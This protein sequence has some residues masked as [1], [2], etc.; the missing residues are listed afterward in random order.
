MGIAIPQVITPDRA[1]G[2]QVI[3]GSLKFDD[4]YLTRTPGSEGNLKSWTWSAWVKLDRV[5]GN[6]QML[7]E[8]KSNGTNYDGIY[9]T[10]GYALEY[11]LYRSSQQ[12]VKITNRVFRDTGWYHLVVVYDAENSTA[13]DRVRIYVNGERETSFSSS[14]NPDT[15]DNSFVN[16]NSIVHQIGD[17]QAANQEYDGRLSQVYLIDGQALDASYFG[18]TDPLTNTWKPKKFEHLSTAI[19]TQYSGASTLTWDDN[20]IGSIYTLSNGNKTATAGGGGSGYSNA[21]VWSIAIPA[22]STYAWTLDITNGDSTGGWYFTD[23]QTDSNTHADE[24]GGNSLGMRPGETH[25]GYHGT[26]ATANGGSDGQNKISMPGASPG[27]GFARVDFVV[28]RPASGTGKVWVKN[29]SSSSWVGGGDPSDT[30]STASFIIPDGTTYFGLTF[31]DRSSDQIATF[32]GDG[33]IQ[34]KIGGNSFYLPFDGNSPIG[35]DQSG[36]GNDWTPVNFGGSV[37]LDSPL[38]SG[39]RSILNTT[40]GGTQAGVGVFGSKQNVGYAVTV[41]NSGGGNKF[42]LDGVEAPTLSNLIRGVTYTFDQSDSS[43][44]THPLVFGSTAEG[45]NFARGALYGSISAGSAGAATTI[46]IPYDAP[47]TLYYHCSAHSGMGG[48]IV[49]IHTDETKADQYAS[50]CVTALPLVGSNNDVSASIA[51]TSTTKTITASNTSHPSTQSNFYSGSIYFDDTADEYISFPGVTFSGEFCVEFWYYPD[52]LATANGTVSVPLSGDT[53]D[54]FQVG[55]TSGNGI[56]FWYDGSLRVQSG[57]IALDKWYHIALTRDSSNVLRLYVDGVQKGNTPT[58]ST[59]ETV[60]TFYLGVQYRSGNADYHRTNGY[61][62]DFRIYNGTVKYSSDFV[63]PSRSPDILPDTPSG[64]VGGS[65]LTKITDGAVAFDG[66][67]DDLHIADSDDL[68]FG[69]GDFT[70]ECFAYHTEDSDDHLISKYGSSSANRSWRLVSDGNQKIIFYWYYSTDSSLNITSAAGKFSLNRWHHIVAQR[71]SGDIYLFVDGE[72]VGSNTSSGA[73]A[74]FNNNSTAVAIAGDLNGSSQDFPGF[75]SNVR[76]VKGTGV[77]STLG[78]TPPSAPL[79]NVTNTKLLCCQSPTSAVEAA[80]KPADVPWL[81]TGYTYWTAGMSQNWANS[82]GTTSNT[83]DYIN[84]ALPTSGKYYWEVTVN[85]LGIY[86]V[87]GISTGAAGVGAN[88]TDNIFGFYYNGNPPIFL[89]RNS[90]GTNRNA[91]GV[92]KNIRNKFI[93]ITND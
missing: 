60:T 86:R 22:D 10:S 26:F 74:E 88:Y 93:T 32:D 55:H 29:N 8:A 18:Y 20:P 21:D 64:V 82:G 14:T 19:T 51:C 63:V 3:N 79:T 44:S 83:N 30:S 68:E 24:R 80:V 16:D 48:S 87:M 92:T 76:I 25:A 45:N 46:T 35:E 42:Y 12:A 4:N 91:S 90:S 69:T 70:I 58:V 73:A 67:G 85:N 7:F 13:A 77:Y 89:V 41:Y 27:P 39:A 15:T 37:E 2:A 59:S 5:S 54:Q 23:S 1:T 81:P 52:A 38:V 28:Y 50:N 11:E 57:A 31:Y 53:L 75:I 84:V 47:E 34:Q 71:T 78:F 43:N 65:K 17:G 61:V 40:Q 36:R 49:G 62:Q 33:S 56:E 66:T 9:F 72:L 6:L